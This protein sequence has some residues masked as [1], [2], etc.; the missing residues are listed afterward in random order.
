MSKA[1]V[2]EVE[3]VV[4]KNY[5]MLSKWNSENGHQTLSNDQRKTSYELYPYFTG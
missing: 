2:I 5:Q 3:G 1:D 4:E